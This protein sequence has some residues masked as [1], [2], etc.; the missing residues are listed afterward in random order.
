LIGWVTERLFYGTSASIV[1][2]Q[3]LWCCHHG[4]TI[5][6]ATPFT[7][8]MRRTPNEQTNESAWS[9][10]IKVYVSLTQTCKMIW[11]TKYKIA[12]NMKKYTQSTDTCIGK[13][14]FKCVIQLLC[15]FVCSDC[16]VLSFSC[17]SLLP[18]RWWHK[19]YFILLALAICPTLS[20]GGF[21]LTVRRTLINKIPQCAIDTE[22]ERRVLYC[23]KFI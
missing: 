23:I 1:A 21:W 4:K 2:G 20:R 5:A 10:P 8:R 6:N 11:S 9:F 22:T 14:Y 16:I 15:I 13:V 12:L 17:L 18:V 3:C 19:V 7:W